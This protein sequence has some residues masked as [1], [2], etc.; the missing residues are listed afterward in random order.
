MGAIEQTL[1][2]ATRIAVSEAVKPLAA[3]LELLCAQESAKMLNKTDA[4][5]YLCVSTP[6]FTKFTK[7][8]GFPKDAC[9]FWARGWLDN[10]QSNR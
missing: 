5:K 2:E 7:Q 6:T 10:W 8:Q 9:G 1:I 3:K 4:A